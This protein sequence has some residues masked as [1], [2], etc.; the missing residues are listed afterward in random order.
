[1]SGANESRFAIASL[2]SAPPPSGRFGPRAGSRPG[3]AAVGPRH[4]G[5][6]QRSNGRRAGG[7]GYLAGL[8]RNPPMAR[9]PRTDPVTLRSQ[10]TL[11]KGLAALT[12]RH[13]ALG[14]SKSSSH[15]G[16]ADTAR[17]PKSGARWR[18][19]AWPSCYLLVQEGTQ[20]PERDPLAISGYR[21]RQDGKNA[22]ALSHKQA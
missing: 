16:L 10:T 4:R 21:S 1:M 9:A 17:R 3:E 5:C 13:R 11:T 19:P 12:T 14:R 22:Y 2:R 8:P 20:R 18:L 15:A 7:C 6:A